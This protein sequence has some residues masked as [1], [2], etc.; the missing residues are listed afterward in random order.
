MTTTIQV[1]VPN[2]PFVLKVTE[3]K[4]HLTPKLV[5]RHDIELVA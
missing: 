1:A 3:R 4:S 5:T 2:I